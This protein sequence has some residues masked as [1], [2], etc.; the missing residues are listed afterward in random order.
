[1]IIIGDYKAI[2]FTYYNPRT[3]LFKAGKS[4][5]EGEN[6]ENVHYPDK[7]CVERMEI[8]VV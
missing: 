6:I 3:S 5:R 2:N 1:M 4:D 8:K 7:R